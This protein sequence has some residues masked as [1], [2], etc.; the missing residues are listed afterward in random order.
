MKR[1]P[2]LF[3][4]TAILALGLLVAAVPAQAAGDQPLKPGNAERKGGPPAV[5]N[6]IVDVA[7]AINAET[8][9]F[10]TLIAAVVCAK[11]DRKLD[12]RGQITVFAPT[13]AAF[14]ELGLDATSVC[15]LPIRDLR[16]ILAYHLTSGRRAA[17]DVVSADRIRMANGDF[18]SITVNDEGAFI[19]DA[20]IVITDVFAD[21]GVIHVIDGVLLPPS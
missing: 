21:N 12:R 14:A 1:S 13:D 15:E 17:A 10:D 4:L 19:N 18:T 3:V 8:G 7:L 5:E 9:E 16:N 11:L 6:S 20:Q 2:L